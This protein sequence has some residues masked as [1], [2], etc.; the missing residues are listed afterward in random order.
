MPSADCRLPRN[1]GATD[2][3]KKEKTDGPGAPGPEL[4]KGWGIGPALLR[5]AD[6]P[7]TVPR[8][9]DGSGGTVDWRA[10]IKEAEELDKPFTEEE[11]SLWKRGLF[12]GNE[13]I[14]S[15]DYVHAAQ[16]AA[17]GRSADQLIAM[18]AAGIPVAP[19]VLPAIALAIS[20]MTTKVAGRPE[21][22][23]QYQDE[24]IR[25]AYSRVLGFSG[26]QNLKKAKAEAKR[27]LA[28]V[29]KVSVKTISRSLARTENAD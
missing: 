21:A 15:K 26:Q 13:R 25:Q 7:A 8:K 17:T 20:N 12:D 3:G 1:S 19:F 29:H 11:L 22:L 14:W 9:T 6:T 2:V 28:S 10:L 16:K 4:P 27:Y 5:G 24:L 23:T 18:M